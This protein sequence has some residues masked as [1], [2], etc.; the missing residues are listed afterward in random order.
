MTERRIQTSLQCSCQFQPDEKAHG[1]S[2]E[3]LW[4]IILLASVSTWTDHFRRRQM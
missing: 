4:F 1:F 3:E 2:W